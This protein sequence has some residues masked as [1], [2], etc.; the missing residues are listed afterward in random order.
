MSKTKKS[1]NL[2]QYGEVYMDNPPFLR[3]GY[4]RNSNRAEQVQWYHSHLIGEIFWVHSR[5]CKIQLHVITRN[6]DYLKC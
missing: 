1:K 2:S 6:F 5:F 3:M 4:P